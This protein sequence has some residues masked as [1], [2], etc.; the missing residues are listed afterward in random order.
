MR[1][2]VFIQ[3]TI[4]VFKQSLF[5]SN[6][7]RNYFRILETTIVTLPESDITQSYKN[8]YDQVKLF[9]SDHV[10]ERHSRI[11]VISFK[12][13][14]SQQVRDAMFNKKKL[15]KPWLSLFKS[16][17][18]YLDEII[19]CYTATLS[20]D[21]PKYLGFSSTFTGLLQNTRNQNASAITRLIYYLF[22]NTVEFGLERE[23][24]FNAINDEMAAFLLEF[25]P[26]RFNALQ[27]SGRKYN[28]HSFFTILL[29]HTEAPN[30]NKLHSLIASGLFPFTLLEDGE[31]N[32]LLLSKPIASLKYFIR[33]CALLQLAQH[34]NSFT[35]SGSIVYLIYSNW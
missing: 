20:T 6:Q 12:N 7:S 31:S 2:T 8:I 10:A 30:S 29:Q 17:M 25:E 33:G 9:E 3:F 28:I 18:I 5:I 21:L 22:L 23:W 26:S 27:Q 35:P 16:I 13:I 1:K 19:E 24:P 11:D 14:V 32:I 34:L 15:P 4:R